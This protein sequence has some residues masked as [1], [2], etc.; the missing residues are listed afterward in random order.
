VFIEPFLIRTLGPV[1]FQTDNLFDV[2]KSVIRNVYGHCGQLYALLLMYNETRMEGILM[3]QQR[4][5]GIY[6]KI[7][8]F[9]I[10]A[11]Y[12]VPIPSSEEVNWR[13]G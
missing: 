12:S 11:G 13:I 6:A 4:I 8:N 9:H 7:E 2:L 5:T 1:Q 3:M 10:E